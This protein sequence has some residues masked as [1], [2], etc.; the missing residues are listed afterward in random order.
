[1]R[2][3]V[4][5]GIS[6][7]QCLFCYVFYCFI[8]YLSHHNGLRV[9]DSFLTTKQLFL[10]SLPSPAKL[11]TTYTFP[12]SP[13]EWTILVQRNDCSMP[14]IYWFR[15]LFNS[16][17]WCE[18]QNRVESSLGIHVQLSTEKAG[19]VTAFLGLESNRCFWQP[20]ILHLSQFTISWMHEHGMVN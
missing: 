7:A 16:N 4:G 13:A 6:Y 10:K 20:N 1:M 14:S 11:V 2:A 18:T 15:P 12:F 19:Q 8:S 17:D 9:L 5:T 3:R